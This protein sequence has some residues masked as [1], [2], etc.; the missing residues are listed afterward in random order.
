MGL[1]VPAA[2]LLSEGKRVKWHRVLAQFGNALA[3][4]TTSKYRM[5]AHLLWAN[6]CW[7]VLTE[8]GWVQAK[9][10]CQQKMENKWQKEYHKKCLECGLG[11]RSYFVLWS[12]LRRLN[13]VTD[14]VSQIG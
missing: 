1:R 9:I 2:L 6:H 12:P 5:Q 14:F 7:H 4:F 13:I 11:G 10:A 3:C 8:D